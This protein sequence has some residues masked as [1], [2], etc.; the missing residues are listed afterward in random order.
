MSL[1]LEL[2]DKNHFKRTQSLYRC[3]MRK[4]WF[5]HGPSSSFSKWLEVPSVG[6]QPP[7]RSA[8]ATSELPCRLLFFLLLGGL[9]A[10]S[11]ASSSRFALPLRVCQLKA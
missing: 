10:P 11:L 6:F 7:V 5:G 2:L 1:L 4:A 9:E 8:L 3:L